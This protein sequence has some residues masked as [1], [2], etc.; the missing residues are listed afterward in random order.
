[1]NVSMLA[2]N[3]DKS[4]LGQKSKWRIALNENAAGA[5]AAQNNDMN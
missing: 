3:M 5:S 2:M 4:N 1:M